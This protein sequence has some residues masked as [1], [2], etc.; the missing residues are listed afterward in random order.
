MHKKETQL[1]ENQRY[2]S[3]HALDGSIATQSNKAHAGEIM[4]H[5]PPWETGS[6]YV[7]LAVLEHTM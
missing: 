1:K 6:H 7:A 4:P 3:M 2:C 5:P